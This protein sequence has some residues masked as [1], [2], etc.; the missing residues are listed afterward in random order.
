MSVNEKGK[1]QPLFMAGASRVLAHG[2]TQGR[3]TFLE[4]EVCGTPSKEAGQSIRVLLRIAW[5]P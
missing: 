3:P 2:V 1:L 4:I 5:P